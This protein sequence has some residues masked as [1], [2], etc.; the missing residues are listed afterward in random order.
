MS[1][2]RVKPTMSHKQQEEVNRSALKW[3]VGS[4]GFIVLVLIVLMVLYL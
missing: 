4:L 2:K 3:V 1:V